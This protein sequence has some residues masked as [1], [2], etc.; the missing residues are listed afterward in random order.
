VV[1][2]LPDAPNGA[3]T[4]V[5]PPAAMLE[6][7]VPAPLKIARNGSEAPSLFMRRSSSPPIKLPPLLVGEKE[8][9]ALK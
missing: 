8:C 5:A 2:P 6:D 4:R 9:L 3:T 1:A 7:A